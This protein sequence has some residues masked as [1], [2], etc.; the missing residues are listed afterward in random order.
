MMVGMQSAASRY[1][2]P[3]TSAAYQNDY[4]LSSFDCIGLRDVVAESGGKGY[5][6]LSAL[7]YLMGWGGPVIHR[8]LCV[9]C[10]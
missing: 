8:L 7:G 5:R 4:C 3:M 10:C 6:T 1:V 9:S 2:G